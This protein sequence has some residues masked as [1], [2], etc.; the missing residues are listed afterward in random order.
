MFDV[1]DG[2]FTIIAPSQDGAEGKCEDTERQQRG[3][4]IRN[5]RER[6]LRQ[7]CPVGIGDV[8]IGDD[9]A[10][11]HNTCQRTDNHR[12]PKCS[13][14]R[15]QC[16]TNGIACLGRCRHDGCRTH[17]ALIGE[18]S[19]G[20]AIAGRHHH[21]GSNKAASCSRGIEGRFDNQLDGWPD[22]AAVHEENHNASDDIEY[23]HERH[24]EGTHTGNGFHTAE[25]DGRSQ[26][27][28]EDADY[29]CGNAKRLVSQQ[30]DGV[31]LHRTADAKRC[32]CR[33][34]GEKHRQPLHA[35]P[36]LKGIHRASIEVTILS[37]DTIFHSQQPFGI[38]R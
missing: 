1:V 13:R 6:H 32:Q 17:T 27:A 33:K 31:G 7:G 29:P 38:F 36:A 11:Q 19:A 30:G 15:H 10:H 28:D 35:K 16:L 21:R 25:D 3:T 23:G 34:H 4:D 26:Q 22:V 24:Q 20:N 14:T 12:V 9:A 2:T 8:G 18:Q 5:L 37:L